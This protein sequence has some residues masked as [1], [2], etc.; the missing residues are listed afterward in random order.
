[1][2]KSIDIPRFSPHAPEDGCRWRGQLLSPTRRPR[3]RQAFAAPAL[4][5]CR[6]RLPPARSFFGT[7]RFAPH[8]SGYQAVIDLY[9]QQVN[10]NV[11]INRGIVSPCRI[12]HQAAVGDGR[13]QPAGPLQWPRHDAGR[14]RNRRVSPPAR[15]QCRDHRSGEERVPAGAVPAIGP[16]GQHLRSLACR[17][18]RAT[19]VSSSIPRWPRKPASRRRRC[20]K[21]PRISSPPRRR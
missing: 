13:R 15:P 3:R 11:T 14:V 16:L 8:E 2:A 5:R 17:I 12:R 7:G 10:A 20:S 21:A 18:H 4:L 19:Q 9:N 6:A 1:M